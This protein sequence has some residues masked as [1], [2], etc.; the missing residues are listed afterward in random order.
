MRSVL[1]LGSGS[2]GLLA[3][4]SLKRKL[5]HL[6]VEVVRSPQLGV[7]GVGEST[8]ASFP[9][10]L[11]DFLQIRRD[12]FYASAD[13][14]W[15][16]GIRFEWGP[17]PWF[18]YSF[19]QGLDAQTPGLSRPNAFYADDDL[20]DVS[21]S[22][23]L[24]AEGRV[25]VPGPDGALAV[26]PTTAFH[27]YNPRLVAALEEGAR[28]AG[29]TFVDAR[30]VGAVRQGEGIAAVVGDDGRQLRADLF[31]DASGFRSTLLGEALAEPFVS[32]ADSLFCDRAIV[33]SWEHA[34]TDPI[35]PYTVAETMDHGWCWRIDHRHAA[36][37][38]YVYSSRFVSDDEARAEFVRKNPR[39]VVSDAPIAFRSGRFAR[40]WVGNVVAVGNACGFVEPLEAT[41][42]MLLTGHCRAIVDVLRQGGGLPGPA[43]R[44]T[45]NRVFADGWDDT[46]DFLA[47]HYRFNRRLDTPFW[48]TCTNEASLAGAAPFVALYQEVG[49]VPLLKYALTKIPAADNAFGLEGWLSLLLGQR[50][51]HAAAFTPSD[52]ERARWATRGAQLRARARTGL[53]A[54]AALARV[55]HPAWRWARDGA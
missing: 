30:I 4:I 36:N 31:V 23:A 34:P 55:H 16:L 8:T 29:V 50:V 12:V 20:E 54:R 38:G 37:R 49:P 14:T 24:M 42:L 48:R 22:N 3:A 2:A 46:R 19:E 40:G 32:Y 35:L 27:L 45:Y 44:A 28:R 47:I 11:F 26:P 7:I 39:A 5:P 52:A 15:K 6:D 10:F 9:R 21:L 43:L 13:P 25:F 41:G 1:I 53:D 33:G 18:P 51:P 17:R